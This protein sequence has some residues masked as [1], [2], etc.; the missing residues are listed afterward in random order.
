METNEIIIA[1][2]IS[3]VLGL[4]VTFIAARNAE[5]IKEDE[6]SSSSKFEP[7]KITDLSSEQPP[8]RRH[9]KKNYKKKPTNAKNAQVDKKPVGR[10]RKSE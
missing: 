2:I 7:R 4:F 9:Y 3:I 1:A 8:K 6:S 5:E 10:P